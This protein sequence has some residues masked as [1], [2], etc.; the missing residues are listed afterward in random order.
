MPRPAPR[1]RSRHHRFMPR[2]TLFR[3]L[4][5]IISQIKER[6]NTSPK[7][8]RCKH[9]LHA[10]LPVA[11]DIE[12]ED[13][14]HD[15]GLLRHDLQDAVRPFRVAG[16]LIRASTG[17][18]IGIHCDQYPVGMVL[19][20]V[21][22]VVDLSSQTLLLFL[23]L[24]ADTTV[25]RNPEL[26]PF[27]WYSLCLWKPHYISGHNKTSMILLNSSI[28]WKYYSRKATFQPCCKAKM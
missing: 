9:G 15:L 11:L 13:F 22:V 10:D 1:S 6:Y 21:C 17:R 2:S 24:G 20:V 26:L 3:L 8:K 25:G 16:T 28:S 7:F 4:S 18:G 5:N 14:S 23:M 27:H 12:I 19:D